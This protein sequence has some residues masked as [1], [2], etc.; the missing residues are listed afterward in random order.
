YRIEGDMLRPLAL[1]R[2]D[3]LDDDLITIQK[4]PGKTNEQFTKL[5]LNVTRLSSSFATEMLERKFS[6]LDPMHAR[7]ATLNQTLMYGFDAY[8]VEMDKQDV[9][10][11]SAFIQRWLKDK[12]LK[13]QASFGPV[14][15]D[16]QIVARRLQVSFA[17][18]KE[19]YKA[20]IVQHIDVVSAETTKA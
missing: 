17:P 15:R 5:L 10:A 13:H 7:G 18:K 19:D 3:P 11:Y 4:H 20:G 1:R 6:V 12:R 16:R 14:R 9:E 2:L 8:G